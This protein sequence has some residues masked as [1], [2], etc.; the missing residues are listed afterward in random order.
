MNLFDYEDNK[1]YRI[2]LA[3]N[4]K[5]VYNYNIEGRLVEGWEFEE[6]EYPVETKIQHFRIGTRDYIVFADR[7]KTYILNRRGNVRI[8]PSSLFRKSRHNLFYLEKY[9]PT[10]KPRFVTTDTS[11][12]L[13][14]IYQD[15]KL[16]KK[17]YGQFSSGHYF[18][19]EDM[20]AD[21]TK[22]YI[23]AENQKLQVI[24]QNMNELFSY[25]FVGD[26]SFKPDIYQFSFKDKELGVV[27]KDENKI[28]LVNRN[29]ELHKGFPLSGSSEF[30]IGKFTPEDDQ[31]HLL[32]GN[33]NIFLYNYQ[34]P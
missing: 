26:I 31:Y 27:I 9:N 3:C 6:T 7:Y 1:N 8:S 28:Y 22:D 5:K 14:Y 18:I 2:L 33:E 13:V 23:F 34:L 11:G 19:A 30:S 10:G 25:E 17:E 16:E 12:Q 20:N 21:G 32:V 24:E 29:G 4:N 15:G